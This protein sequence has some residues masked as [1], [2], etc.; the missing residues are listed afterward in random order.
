[1]MMVPM[2]AST[3]ISHALPPRHEA[4]P[5]GGD[6]TKERVREAIDI[7]D[8][9]GSYISLRRN[10]RNLVGLCPWHDDS[11]PSLQ[12]N[13][14]RQTFRCWVCNIGG[15][16]FSFLMRME[17][18]EFREALEQLAE[19]AGIDLP[20]S[21]GPGG[22]VKRPLFETVAWAA[23]RFS[24]CLQSSPLAAKARA[25]LADRG[26]TA[27][28][29]AAH[30]L[31][32]V[33]D[34]WDW[35]LRQAQA[36]GVATGKLEQAGL[37]VPRQDRSG[38]YDRFRGRVMFPIRDPQGRHVAFGGRVLPGSPPDAAK[39]INSPETAIFSKQS[40]LYGL[41]TARET[42]SRSRRAVVVEG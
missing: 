31:G 19:R 34:E 3:D 32:F 2:A 15:D 22:D 33:P 40:M 41:E 24:E 36:A 30:G 7:V 16:A 10:G 5:L 35:L 6:D 28:T 14:E 9:I 17:R 39:Y 12:I 37:A 29:V 11:R 23:A 26:L 20:K 4:G 27:E 21:R 8:L 42:M 13:P 25:Y 1:M 18:L 38:H